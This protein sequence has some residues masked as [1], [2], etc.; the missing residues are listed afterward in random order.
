MKTY[1]GV[2]LW[3]HTFLTSALDGS[4]WSAS[5]P[6]RFTPG[7]RDPGTNRIGCWVGPRAGL[8]TVV[9]RQIPNPYK[10]INICLSDACI[11]VYVCALMTVLYF[12]CFIYP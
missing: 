11:F 5:R 3:P 1:W 6:D 9:K 7:E 10:T 4:E 8:F 12:P 2:E